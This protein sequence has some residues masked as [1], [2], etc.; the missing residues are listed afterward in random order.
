MVQR[1]MADPRRV[2]R[3]TELR[4][5]LVRLIQLSGRASVP[6]MIAGLEYWGFA[7]EGRPSKTICDALRWER[8]RG[9][10]IR[11]GRGL[12]SAGEMP[13]STEHRIITRVHA[14]RAE[15]GTLPL[16]DPW[17]E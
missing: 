14:L 3:G 8:R 7:V 17:W 2:L 11:R 4:Y 5:A 10:V 9:R 1:P 15:A 16:E 6:E 12:Y 13:R